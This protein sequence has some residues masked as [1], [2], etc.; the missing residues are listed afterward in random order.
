MS[1]RIVTRVCLEGYADSHQRLTNASLQGFRA[2]ARKE[3]AHSPMTCVPECPRPNVDAGDI[4]QQRIQLG[5]QIEA[6]T[7]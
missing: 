4:P 7:R 2:P 6:S 1:L 3:N 5:C